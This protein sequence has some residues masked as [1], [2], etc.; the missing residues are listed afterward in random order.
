MSNQ[1]V[2]P[3]QPNPTNQPYRL[4][5]WKPKFKRNKP[6]AMLIFASRNSGKSYLMRHLIRTHLRKINDIIVIVSDSPD[7]KKD[8]EPCCG[9]NTIF[10]SDMNFTIINNL[11]AKNAKRA[12]EGKEPLN[13]L[14]IFDDKIGNDIK[15]DQNLLNVFTRGRHLN[16]SVIFSSQSKKLAETT[17][18]NN[19]DYTIMLKSNSAQQKKTIL[20]NVLRGSINLDDPRTEVQT[21]TAIVRE[22]CSNQGDALVIDSQTTANDNLFWYRAP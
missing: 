14:L 12:Q 11:T 1:P 10:L 5:K 18:L 21:L 6:F 9:P 15:N 17:W 8:F 7:T 3:I 4:R 16:L 19:A 20:E 13:M 2:Q 22:Y